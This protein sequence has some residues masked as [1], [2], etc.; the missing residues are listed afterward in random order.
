M[1]R[2]EQTFQTIYG[3]L[4][5]KTLPLLREMNFGAWEG[6]SFEEIEQDTAHKAAFDDW[7]RVTDGSFAFPEGGDSVN[8]FYARVRGGLAELEGLHRLKELSCR[9]NGN[10]AVSL[11]VW[12]PA[13]GHGYTISFADG[14]AIRDRAFCS[15]KLPPK[16][17][18]GL[19][20]LRGD[21][22]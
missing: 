8:S 13:P 19:L 20:A 11:V 18:R 10:D 9:H 14:K 7:M 21:F 22:L 3:D 4:P 17:P 16:N 2:T 12:I 5:H 1:L 6:M 15:R